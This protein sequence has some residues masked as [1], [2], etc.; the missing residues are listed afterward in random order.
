MNPTGNGGMRRIN[1][2]CYIYVHGS[3]GWN[4]IDACYL[5]F[6]VFCRRRQATM[7]KRVT[8]KTFGP[9]WINRNRCQHSS[10]TTVWV[11]LNPSLFTPNLLTRFGLNGSVLTGIASP[12]YVGVMSLFIKTKVLI[13]RSSIQP[14]VLGIFGKVSIP[15]DSVMSVCKSYSVSDF[16]IP[17]HQGVPSW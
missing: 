4:E 3:S 5:V 11:Y 12:I 1:D 6:F 2:S 13:L 15:T 14:P 17:L 10:R 9:Q 16:Y 7:I 8:T